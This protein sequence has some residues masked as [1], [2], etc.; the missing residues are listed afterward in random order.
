MFSLLSLDFV[1]RFVDF[2]DSVLQI[3]DVLLVD[4]ARRVDLFDNHSREDDDSIAG[5]V[6]TVRKVVWRFF[7]RLK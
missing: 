6:E 3:V 7:R 1:Q 2:I 4:V 5:I